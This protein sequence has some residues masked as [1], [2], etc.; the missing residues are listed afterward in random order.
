MYEGDQ[1][2][3]FNKVEHKV[4]DV[5]VKHSI[6]FS[7]LFLAWRNSRG[8]AER[9][10]T[11]MITS[12]YKPIYQQ[13]WIDTVTD[14]R[15]LLQKS[16]IQWSVELITALMLSGQRGKTLPILS[17]DHDLIHGWSK[18]RPDFLVRIQHHDWV[19]IDVLY[20]GYVNET[21]ATISVSACDANDSSWDTTL[22]DLRQVLEDHHLDAKVELLFSKGLDYMLMNQGC[23]EPHHTV[24]DIFYNRRLSM[25]TSC[26]TSGSDCSG[27]LGGWI[28]LK[29][30]S[31]L[32]LGLTNYHVLRNGLP[33]DNPSEPF[34]PIQGFS[35]GD[36]VSPSNN[37]HKNATN[38][39]EKEI[40]HLK[41][42]YES[43]ESL[44][45]NISR[46]DPIWEKQFRIKDNM[47]NTLD[48]LRNQL[49]YA[50]DYSR[51]AGPIYS[52]SG[53]RTRKGRAIDWCLFW[54]KQPC[55]I[56]RTLQ[57]HGM[58]SNL[59]YISSQDGSEALT[60][61]YS[62]SPDKNYE[63]AKRGRTSGWTGGTLSAIDTTICLSGKHLHKRIPTTQYIEFK[64]K[65]GGKAVCVHT[66]TS[67]T[68]EPFIGRGDSGAFVLLNESLDS[69]GKGLAII[70][71][72]FAA[73]DGNL[74][75]YMMPFD[76]LVEDIEDVTGGKVI[77]PRFA[78]KL[79]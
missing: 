77:E 33:Q 54:V 18:A 32:D 74:A 25:G 47:E 62:I 61:Y 30:E 60:R 11:L 1:L 38:L 20:R 21:Y 37:D 40:R 17:T 79:D 9:Q 49:K 58:P 2:N 31:T 39:L 42:E 5:L 27:T 14:I 59:G 68:A 19:A 34:P 26:T 8:D 28:R 15:L 35:Y 56:S 13:Q 41:A 53:F 3:D 55:L 72:G 64:D 70:G 10:L 66:I 12:E 63:V 69:T 36:V 16:E 52:A 71:M 46:D 75:S 76:V 48:S 67:T 29:K 4:K 23:T 65:F 22:L 6:V 7:H 57:I 78:G 51:E 43:L 50:E 44:L 73:N 45:D 24:R